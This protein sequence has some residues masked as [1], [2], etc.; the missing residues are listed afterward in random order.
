LR[1]AMDAAPDIQPSAAGEWQIGLGGGLDLAALIILTV[2]VV[3]AVIWTWRSLDPAHKLSFR[4]TVTVLRAIALVTGLGLILQPSIRFRRFKGAPAELAVLVDASGSMARGGEDSRLVRVKRIAEAAAGRLGQISNKLTVSWYRFADV[5]APDGSTPSFEPLLPGLGSDVRSAVEGLIEA[6]GGASL[7]G[8]VVVGDGADT[9][10]AQPADGE[11]DMS[12]ATGLGIPIN[13]VFIGSRG[14]R[15]DL[16]IEDAEVDPF[17]FTRSETPIAVTLKSVGLS[18][19]EV[20][21][22]LWQ[23]GSVVQRR[24]V[25][26]VGGKG[27]VLFNVLPSSLGQ[28]VFTVTVPIPEGDEVEENN[29]VHLTFEVVRDKFRVLHLAGRPSWDQRFLRSTFKAWPQIDL[30]SFYVLRT[31]YQSTAHGSSGMALIPFPTKDL[32]EDY[33]D[34]FDVVILQ[35]FDP[36]AVGVDRYLD[37]IARFVDQG[38]ALVLIGGSEGLNATQLPSQKFLD[39]L[40]VKLLGPGVPPAMLSDARPFRLRLTDVGV[41]HPLTRLHQ[42]PERNEE[43]YRSS[44]RLDGIGRVASLAA[45]AFRLAEHPTVQ[46]GDGPAPVIAVRDVNKGRSMVV[47]TDSLWRWGFSGPMTGGPANTYVTFWR[48]AIAWL[49]RAPVL[50]RLRVEVEPP[51]VGVGRPIEFSMELLDEVYRPVPAVPLDCEISWLR[52]DGS[53]ETEQFEVLLDAEGRYRREWTPREE[54]PHRLK[55]AAASGQE[56]TV[57]FLASS[58]RGELAQLEPRRAL[59][60]ELARST[61]GHFEEGLMTPESWATGV[62]SARRVQTETELP[63]WDHPLTVIVFIAL[64][65]SEWLLRRRRGLR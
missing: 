5:L 57:R 15:R 36:T 35:E 37:R 52:Q 16:A 3:A 21:A 31:A 29:R 47:A 64:I 11:Y 32:F 62:G 10:I 51:S 18:D 33:L 2:S 58:Q 14:E 17:A 42:S 30:V 34:E 55:V 65:A 26:L 19:R 1:G 39:S 27:R 53:E 40:P 8:I 13:A 9:E 43:L 56:K 28:H 41:T 6:K 23:D 12:W 4:L 44:T 50:D 20:E 63:L 54:G 22:F 38:G 7:A 24:T 46:A 61:G 48:Q 59:L 45:G 25:E 49:T 60:E